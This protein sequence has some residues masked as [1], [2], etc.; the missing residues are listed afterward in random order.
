MRVLFWRRKNVRFKTRMTT[1]IERS[2]AVRKSFRRPPPRVVIDTSFLDQ[3]DA[4]EYEDYDLEPGQHPDGSE[5]DAGWYDGE[6]DAAVLEQHQD[7]DDDQAPPRHGRLVGPA[8]SD[9]D[10]EPEDAQ[11]DVRDGDFERD[12]GVFDAEAA[13]RDRAVREAA[14]RAADE[15][16][17]READARRLAEAEREIAARR[18]EDA[19]REVAALRSAAEERERQARREAEAQRELA[20]RRASE[21]RADAEARKLAE[22]ERSEE[23]Q[24]GQ[25]CRSRW[26]PYQ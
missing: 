22:A 13:E 18:A 23:R 4:A 5:Q 14:E 3:A 15:A 20:L 11:S 10:A 25:E 12:G 2:E 24:G 17:M 7:Q 1:V 6:G 8:T 21:A 19:E 9:D 26:S 16:F